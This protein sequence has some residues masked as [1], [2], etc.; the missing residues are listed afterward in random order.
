M[1]DEVDRSAEIISSNEN[2]DE[3]ARTSY[4]DRSKHEYCHALHHKCDHIN[5]YADGKNKWEPF[6]S[7]LET[8][9]EYDMGGEVMPEISSTAVSKIV[10]DISRS[11]VDRVCSSLNQLDQP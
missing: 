6:D 9:H 8:C 11:H 10:F 1:D 2:Y 7:D 3:D 5:P 4:D